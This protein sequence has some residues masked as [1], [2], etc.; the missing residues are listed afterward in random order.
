MLYNPASGTRPG[1]FPAPREPLLTLTAKPLTTVYSVVLG[2]LQVA[3]SG[4]GLGFHEVSKMLAL[5]TQFEG[6]APTSAIK[7]NSTFK[8]E[9]N[10]KKS[11]L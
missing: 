2:L 3:L 4:P 11:R 10:T 5:G 6:G 9:I 7:I 1:F 8:I